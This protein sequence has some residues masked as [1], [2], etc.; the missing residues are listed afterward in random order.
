[1]RSLQ[2]SSFLRAT[3]TGSESR[4][5]GMNRRNL[6][7]I[8]FKHTLRPGLT[9]ELNRSTEDYFSCYDLLKL[10]WITLGA[11]SNQY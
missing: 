6:K 7:F 11:H 3:F 1:M 2:A 9:L 4:L 10:M 8:N 5:E